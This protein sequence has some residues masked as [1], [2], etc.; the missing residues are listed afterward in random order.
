MEFSIGEFVMI[1]R[2]SGKWE[3]GEVIEVYPN[4]IVVKVKITDNFQGKPYDGPPK[5][6]YKIIP[7]EKFET[8]LQK[9][10]R[11]AYE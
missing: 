7:E 1:K 5:D 9:M 11:S 6:G 2:T 10:K 8:H 4:K 3:E